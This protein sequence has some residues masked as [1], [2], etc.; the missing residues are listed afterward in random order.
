MLFFTEKI[1]KHFFKIYMHFDTHVMPKLFNLTVFFLWQSY[2]CMN[3]IFWWLEFCTPIYKKFWKCFLFLCQI[4]S[5]YMQIICCH[6]PCQPTPPLLTYSAQTYFSKA[7][8]EKLLS[9]LMPFEHSW[10]SNFLSGSLK[11]RRTLLLFQKY[12]LI[13]MYHLLN[14]PKFLSLN[15]L[16]MNSLL[17]QNH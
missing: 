11:K 1:T 10:A 17:P 16:T 13:H 7:T 9:N 4:L 5:Q 3:Q 8:L 12:N 15:I 6:I 2:I 14:L